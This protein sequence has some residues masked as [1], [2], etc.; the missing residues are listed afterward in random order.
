MVVNYFDASTCGAIF[1]TDDIFLL[2]RLI[3]KNSMINFCV[4]YRLPLILI[5]IFPIL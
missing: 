1:R 3:T 4:K 2:R 5:S